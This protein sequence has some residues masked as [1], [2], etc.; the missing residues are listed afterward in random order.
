MKI[1]VCNVL[2]RDE[3]CRCE[4]RWISLYALCLIRWINNANYVLNGAD[5]LHLIALHPKK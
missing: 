1:R 2:D 4:M 5:V 3:L